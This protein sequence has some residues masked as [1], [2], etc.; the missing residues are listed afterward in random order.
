MTEATGWCS[1][2]RDEHAC[3]TSRTEGRPCVWTGSR[4]AKGALFGGVLD[5]TLACPLPSVKLNTG[6]RMPMLAFGTGML[7][8]HSLERRLKQLRR[9]RSRSALPMLNTSLALGITHI[10]TSE[11]YPDFD[12]LGAALRPHRGRLFIT[13]K[14]DPTTRSAATRCAHDGGGC[15]AAMLYA[16]NTTVRRLSLV[17]DLLLLHRPP[18]I[19]G[20]ASDERTGSV[21]CTQ[22]RAAWRGLEAAQRVGLTRAIGLSNVCGHLLRCLAT[23]VRVRPAVLQYMH[24]VGMGIDPFGYRTF[25]RRHWAAEYMAYSVLGGA[26]LDFDRIVRSPTVVSVAAAHGTQPADVAVAWVVQQRIPL[27]VTS[28]KPAH[29]RANIRAFADEPPSGLLTAS[30]M[31]ALSSLQEPAGRPSHWGSC[32]DASVEAEADVTWRDRTPVELR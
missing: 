6:Q 28:A 24:H 21:Q 25:G 26:E 20:G 9:R 11:V 32:T 18:A 31:K 22:L 1:G 29:L 3:H 17:P 16:A 14:V 13:S 8:L 4:C 30:E 27:V 5:D 10:D 2:A 19:R 15:D 12:A 7:P 23:T